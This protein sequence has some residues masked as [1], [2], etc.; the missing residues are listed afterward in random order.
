MTATPFERIGERIRATDSVLSVGLDPALDRLPDAVSDYDYPRRAFNR[1]IVDATHEHVAAYSANLAFY[2]DPDGWT[3]LA[4]TIAYAQGKGVPVVLDGKRADIGNTSSQY[5]K[6][7]DSADAV[8]V[9][10]YLGRDALDPF[11][12]RETAVFVA[13]R[14]P[15]AGAV[16][17]QT[18]ELA[19]GETL[20]ERVASLVEEWAD[21]AAADVGLLVGG[22]AE[23][24][25][26]LRER[27]PDLPFFVVGGARNDP[28]VAA[29]AVPEGAGV[30]LVN[31]S[32]E[33][34]YAGVGVAGGRGGE[35]AFAAAAGQA[36]RRLAR[37]LNR[38]R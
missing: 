14:T 33:V 9:N 25:E 17:L 32:R 29:F 2:E 10:P 28:E 20:A 36:A 16:D 6:L 21:D 15:N 31:V 4:E 38:H 13:C 35:D 19:G 3:A 7:A 26:G 34:I 30:G 23:A 12:E 8:T 11:F 27:A 18:R 24:V 22:D 1:R 37:Q 5:A